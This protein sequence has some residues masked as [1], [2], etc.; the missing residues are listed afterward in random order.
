MDL[1]RWEAFGR[2][3]EYYNKAVEEHAKEHPLIMYDCE[4]CQNLNEVEDRLKNDAPKWLYNTA[5]ILWSIC[6][7]IRAWRHYRNGEE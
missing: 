1:P 2:R 4:R 3:L 5:M 7:P 6:H